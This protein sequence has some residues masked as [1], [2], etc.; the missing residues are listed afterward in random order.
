MEAQPR[1]KKK[2]RKTIEELARKNGM[3]MIEIRKIAGDR[4]DWRR[5]IQA[6]QCIRDGERNGRKV[7]PWS[8]TFNPKF[9]AFYANLSSELACF[10]ACSNLDIIFDLDGTRLHRKQ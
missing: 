3:R 1:G 8:E 4:R 6:I 10:V 7:C 2:L 5:W 9:L